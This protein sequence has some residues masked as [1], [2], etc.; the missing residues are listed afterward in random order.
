[1]SHLP[2]TLIS[3]LQEININSKSG[4]SKF[5]LIQLNS[6]IL[7]F[8]LVPLLDPEDIISLFLT[9]KSIHSK[10]D[11]D[12]V[13]HELYTKSFHSFPQLTS[14]PINPEIETR[15]NSNSESTTPTSGT[16]DTNISQKRCASWH[17]FYR[18][19]KRARFYS[20]GAHG[21]PERLGDIETSYEYIC[22]PL[23]SRIPLEKRVGESISRVEAGGYSFQ[24][25]T[26]EGKLYSTGEGNLGLVDTGNKKVRFFSSG[27][28]EYIAIDENNELL[29]GDATDSRADNTKDIQEEESKLNLRV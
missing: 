14:V 7:S 4:S 18:L 19:R 28:V 12:I 8:H 6:D 29:V 21:D 10:L 11:N 15:E 26:T 24:I 23:E 9:C 27:R 22:K 20:W 17:N 13:W 25:L 16:H 2:Q 5:Q 1:M 3:S